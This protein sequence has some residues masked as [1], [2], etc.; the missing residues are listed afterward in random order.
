LGGPK[1]HFEIFSSSFPERAGARRSEQE[2]GVARRSQKEPQGARRNQEEPGRGAR[3]QG[4][5]GG[6]RSGQEQP[7]EAR[8]TRRSQ[9]EP[10]GARRG[11]KGPN[12]ARD[13]QDCKELFSKFIYRSCK[14]LPRVN[15]GLDHSAR[16]RASRDSI[17]LSYM[18]A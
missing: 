10:G 16:V 9:E 13:V 17:S 8:K 14:H 7:G 12:N 5:P 11:K 6:A 1:A 2:P 18:H 4:E 15:Q 3:S